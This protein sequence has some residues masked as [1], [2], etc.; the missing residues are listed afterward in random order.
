[1]ELTS[2]KLRIDGYLTLDASF[3]NR[4]FR[5]RIARLGQEGTPLPLLRYQY[6]RAEISA[7]HKLSKKLRLKMSANYL[8]RFSNTEDIRESTRRDYNN[9][10]VKTGIEYR[11]SRSKR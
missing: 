11:L 4:N 7:Q 2:G 10:E 6:A 3:A 8:G 1:M 9:Y 5:D